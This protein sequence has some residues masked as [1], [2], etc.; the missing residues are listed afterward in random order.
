MTN[1]IH[2]K[3]LRSGFQSLFLFL[4]FLFNLNSNLW[5][6]TESEKLALYTPQWIR[7]GFAVAGPT[8]EPWMF[9]MRRN[10]SEMDEHNYSYWQKDEYDEMMSEEFIK[11]FAE[12]GATVYHLGFYK[13]FGFKAEK[14]YMDKA[15]KAAA[16]AH[17][18]NLKV[19]TYIQ[20]STM[21]HE[22]F[23]SEVP[24]AKTEMWYQFDVTGKPLLPYGDRAPFR[25]T[26]C[27]SNDAYINYLKEK[28]IRYAVEVVKTDFIHFDNFVY[29][30]I[31]STDHNPA[32]INAFRKY[33]KDKYSPV[34]RFERFGF[35]DVSN[36]LP[37]AWITPPNMPVIGDPI[38]QEWIDFR[39]WTLEKR[40]EECAIFVRKLNKEVVIEVN[41]GGLVGNNK[42]WEIGVN[43]PS[44]MKYTNVIWAE[45]RNY[46][47]WENGIITG[48]YRSFKLG[49]TT[50][51]FILTYVKTPHDFAENLAL[52]R[53][54]GYLDEGIPTGVGKKYLDFW[55]ANK[56][57]Y[58]N[59][60][61][62]EKVATFRSYPSM[63][64][65]TY[66]T[67][68][69]ANMAEQV[70]QQR[71]IPFDIIFD[72]QLDNLKKYSVLVL[73]DQECLTDEVISS[74]KQFVKNGG[75]LVMTNKTGM[76]DGWHRRRKQGMLEELLSEEKRDDLLLKEKKSVLSFTY[77]KGRVVYLPELERPNE[78]DLRSG[79][80]GGDW[81]LPKNA[82]ELESAVYWVS[83]ERL[84][85]KVTSPEWVGVSH[86]SQEKM[87]V[88]HLFNYKH[89][90][91]VAGIIL[92]YD[93]I[94]KNAWSISPD[95]EG[96]SIIPIVEK[97]GITSLRIPNLEVYKIVVL[98]K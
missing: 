85:L 64:Y 86:D 63:A 73:A 7:D 38:I 8:W 54:I 79:W 92:E 65:N 19:A 40:L 2:N 76:Y 49:R 23:F 17:K 14:E 9:L 33:I 93:G 77:G 21:C 44:L 87:D 56:K 67:H 78:G 4:C 59:M 98:E 29:S 32:T 97:A 58:T 30:P 27:F 83:G 50:N 15:A 41:C 51:T 3:L 94:V 91:N 60:Q 11:S 10:N 52:N 82:N 5:A 95:E 26:P 39:C 88:I 57:L 22:T 96:K 20:W 35:D 53:S 75:G 31:L 45:D 16:I 81:M 69:V 90:S 6:Q 37:P 66:E 42:P 34:K 89:N 1:E 12:S 70:L 55:L 43:H 61:G 71:Q 13:G 68:I 25:F 72:Q 47:K 36:M 48:K 80:H 46:P 24:E 28:I 62:V 84:P 74:L 18:Y